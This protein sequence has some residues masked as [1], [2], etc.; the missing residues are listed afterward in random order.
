MRSTRF[1]ILASSGTS[2]AT[3]TVVALPPDGSASKAFGRIS[4][5]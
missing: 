2:A 3:V 5:I 4:A 1:A